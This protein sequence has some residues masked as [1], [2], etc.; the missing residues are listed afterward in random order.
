MQNQIR[1]QRNIKNI[2][3]ILLISDF[4]N[5]IMLEMRFHTIG[6]QQFE[7]FRWFRRCHFILLMHFGVYCTSKCSPLKFAI[8]ALLAACAATIYCQS[9]QSEEHQHNHRQRYCIHLHNVLNKLYSKM[10]NIWIQ[11]LVVNDVLHES[12]PQMIG[13]CLPIYTTYCVR[14]RT[15]VGCTSTTD[16]HV[17]RSI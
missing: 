14:W 9:S 12:C 10:L 13:A 15:L 1:V 16:M 11:F 2:A 3:P 4:Y 8:L 6:V 5:H 7:M 17:A